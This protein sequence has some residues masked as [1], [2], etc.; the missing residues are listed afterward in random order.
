ME[1]Y[2]NGTVSA[3]AYTIVREEC[4]LTTATGRERELNRVAEFM[5]AQ[6]VRMPDL[7]GFAMMLMTVIF[8][9]QTLLFFGAPFNRLRHEHRWEHIL[10]WRNSRI[11]PRRDLIRFWESLAVLGWY[12]MTGEED[13]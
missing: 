13:S 3:L 7:L 4:G 1:A 11:G 12:S 9:L 2:L 10:A 8:S 6:R 5:A